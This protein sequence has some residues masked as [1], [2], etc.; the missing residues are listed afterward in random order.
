[1]AVRSLA[2]L[3]IS[4]GLVSIPVKLHSAT[5]SAATPHF[6]LLH[7]KDGSRLREQYVCAKE[8]KVV[9]RNEIVK[10]YEFSKGRYVMF[11]DSEIKA[12]EELGTHSIELEEFA[13]LDSVDPVYFDRTYYL[14]ADKGGARPYALFVRALHDSKRC[15]VGRWAS[16]GR[17]HVVILRALGATLA[18][19][20]LHFAAEV[21]EADELGVTDAAIREPELKL[22]RQLI[23][24]RTVERFDPSAYSDQVTARIQEAIKK[25]VEG[26]EFSV[27]EPRPARAENV[28]D[29]AAALRASLERRP[30]KRAPRS[31]KR[32][33]THARAAHH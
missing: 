28:I 7:K 2:S 11:N 29:L 23:D 30:A 22:A 25:K 9:G 18:L 32:S 24:Q 16:R 8:G 17:D 20:Q 14:T 4:F 1:M 21:R 5:R 3:T 13:P 12:L 19:Q 10:G 31:T 15:A 6:H 26:E 33:G 27:S